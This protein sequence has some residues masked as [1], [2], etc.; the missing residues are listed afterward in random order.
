MLSNPNC[1]LD[2]NS[3]P[4]S[5]KTYSVIETI[6]EEYE[7]EDSQGNKVIKKRKVQVRKKYK[8][9]DGKLVEK[10]RGKRRV[11]KRR[12]DSKG[13][14]IEYSTEESYTEGEKSVSEEKLD[15]I[16]RK[17]KDKVREEIKNM[18]NV[19]T[20]SARVKRKFG[21]DDRGYNSFVDPD[22]FNSEMAQLI[23]KNK[24]RFEDT[25]TTKNKLKRRLNSSSKD[26]EYYYDP[27]TGRKRRICDSVWSPTRKDKSKFQFADNYIPHGENCGPN[28]FHLIR[29]NL[30]KKKINRRLLP[31]NT[32]NLDK[33]SDIKKN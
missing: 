13:N 7:S 30:Y 25:K 9:V 26:E 22:D 27:K 18:A 5:N 33:F 15:N 29:A 31:M 16:K 23:G 8:S 10:V 1:N 32:N 4:E 19:G 20:I 17:L 12:K 28:C 2:Y 21:E 24:N 6:S 3:D 11:K 14:S